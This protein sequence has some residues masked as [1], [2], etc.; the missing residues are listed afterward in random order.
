MQLVDFFE[1]V[2]EDPRIST[3]HISLYLAMVTVLEVSKEQEWL[4][5]E[6]RRLMQLSKI[7]ARSTYQRIIHEL[8]EF[9]YI[10]YRPSYTGK[11]KLRFK[12]L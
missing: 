4:I 7:S 5:L 2:C 8:H 11:S 1:V 9:G 10:E 12:K 3:R 6:R